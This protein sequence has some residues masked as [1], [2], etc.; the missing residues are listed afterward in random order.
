MLSY[1]SLCP[2]ALLVLPHPL[3]SAGT[4]LLPFTASAV[5]PWCGKNNVDNTLTFQLLLSSA[6]QSQ[7]CSV[8][9]LLTLPGQQGAEG[10]GTGGGWSWDRDLNQRDMA[11]HMAV[12]AVTAELRGAE[13]LNLF[14]P[15]FQ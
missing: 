6:A 7:G 14:C 2:A 11:Q 9:L 12:C 3:G 1:S 15:W 4:E 5:M 13:V 10:H 8:S